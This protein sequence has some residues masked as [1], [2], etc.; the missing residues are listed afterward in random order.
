MGLILETLLRG[1]IAGNHIYRVYEA[2]DAFYFVAVGPHAPDAETQAGAWRAALEEVADFSVSLVILAQA[3][4]L[5][6]FCQQIAQCGLRERFSSSISREEVADSSLSG[7]VADDQRAQRKRQIYR[8]ALAYMRDH[9]HQDLSRE[10][11]AGAVYVSQGYLSHLFSEMAGMSFVE[12]LT[13]IRMER[14][15]ALLATNMRINDIAERVGYRNRKSFLVNFRSYT[16][17]TPSEYRQK[18]W[19]GGEG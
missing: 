6:A 16:G 9:V 7:E 15:V 1:P 5:F 14:A 19:M 10:D 11:V 3:A 13:Q 8:R 18:Y 12:C 17:L 4:G 2:A